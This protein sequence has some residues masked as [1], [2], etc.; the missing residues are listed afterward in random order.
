MQ[1]GSGWEGSI[2]VRKTRKMGAF[3]GEGNERKG[4]DRLGRG[5][6]IQNEEEETER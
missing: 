3:M 5:V 2:N 4:W 1:A 6:Q